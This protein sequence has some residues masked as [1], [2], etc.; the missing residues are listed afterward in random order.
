MI[1]EA[2]IPGPNS[3]DEA[4]L[5]KWGWPSPALIKRHTPREPYTAW[6]PTPEQQECPF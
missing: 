3:G 1:P 5:A 2:E 6:K 4:N